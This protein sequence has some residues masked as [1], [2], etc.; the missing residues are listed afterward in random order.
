VVD[1][2]FLGAEAPPIRM[3]FE[4]ILPP[5]KLEAAARRAI[6]EN[7]ENRPRFATGTPVEA[8]AV[9]G[10]MWAQNR[11]LRIKFLGGDQ[12]VRNRV[13]RWANVWTGYVNL[14]FQWVGDDEPADIRIDARYNPADGS[15]SFIGTD[16]LEIGPAEPMDGALPGTTMRLGWLL[17][18]SD[19]EEYSAVVLH[20]FGHGAVALIHEHQSPAANIP[21]NRPRV[22]QLLGGPPNNWPKQTIDEN[23]FD[24]LAADQTQYTQMDPKSIM[25]YPI[26]PSLTLNGFSVGWNTTLSPLDIQFSTQRYPRATPPSVPT[27]TPTPTPVPGPAPPPP[28]PP[29]PAPEPSAAEVIVNARPRLQK[30][31]TAGGKDVYRFTAPHAGIYIIAAIQVSGQSAYTVELHGPR[32][33]NPNHIDRPGLLTFRLGAGINYF[34]VRA[35]DGRSTGQYAV[36]VRGR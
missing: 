16:A 26:D 4:R 8:A 5:H 21:W 27:P 13:M 33:P 34:A 31:G 28:P 24:R 20:E 25:M 12:V 7:P 3:C 29:P 18:T 9:T 15:W 30:L 32:Y 14:K 10:K 36:S 22:Y 35:A 23:M 6:E 11:T 2:D 19:D 1:F 17:P